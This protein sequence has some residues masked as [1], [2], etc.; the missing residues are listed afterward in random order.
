[1]GVRDVIATTADAYRKCIE[2]YEL[3]G[4]RRANLDRLECGR[5]SL[6]NGNCSS[7]AA[8]RA[9]TRKLSAAI[10]A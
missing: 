2:A 3:G 8:A 10:G 1:V 7:G 5:A 6:H 9:M 4:L